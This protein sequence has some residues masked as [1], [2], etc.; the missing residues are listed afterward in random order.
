MIKIKFSH[1]YY[2]FPSAYQKSKIAQIIVMDEKDIS[3]SF[4]DYDT[5][6]YTSV[7]RDNYYPLPKGKVIIIILIAN[8]GLG[9]IWTTIRRWTPEKEQYYRR[10]VG[11]VVE[12]EVTET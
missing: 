11:Q 12:C 10:L 7:C 2:K 5:C 9:W 3:Q 6:Y 8:S 1:K 4:R